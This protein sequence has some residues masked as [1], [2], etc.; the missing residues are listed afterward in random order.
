MK[1]AEQACGACCYPPIL[2]AATAHSCHRRAPKAGRLIPLL[3]STLQV[4]SEGVN[5]STAEVVD[6][7]SAGRFN[8][9]APEP[10]AGLRGGHIPNSKNVFFGDVLTPDGRLRPAEEVKKVFE[11]AGLDLSR[12]ASNRVT[13]ALAE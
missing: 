4:L 13:R 7:R 8:G 3:P 9:T 10:R 5:A 12:Y 11:G 1:T 2:G 6:A